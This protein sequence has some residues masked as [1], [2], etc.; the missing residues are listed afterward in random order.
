M[1]AQP[2]DFYFRQLC[3]GKG[4]IDVEDMDHADLEAFAAICGK[5]LAFAHARS[6]GPM[7]IRGYIGKEETFDEVMVEFAT[8]YADQTEQDHARL[9][10][11]IDDGAIKVEH[12]I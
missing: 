2:I 8:R 6:G 4:K 3:D 1:E 7:M 11:A 9:V 5:T 12:D 10:Q